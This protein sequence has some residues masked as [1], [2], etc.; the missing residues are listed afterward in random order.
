MVKESDG[1]VE[2]AL[3]VVREVKERLAEKVVVELDGWDFSPKVAEASPQVEVLRGELVALLESANVSKIVLRNVQH[4]G[5]LLTNKMAKTLVG[6][7]VH[8]TIFHEHDGLVLGSLIISS[9]VIE[10]VV[11]S[12][13]DSY[14]K[15]I[16]SLCAKLG[17]SQTLRT[18]DFSH[19][20][21]MGFVGNV[22]SQV[23][24]S[25]KALAHISL[26]HNQLRSLGV[27]PIARA[28]ANSTQLISIALT[29]NHIEKAGLDDLIQAVEALP[30][31][32]PLETVVLD[33]N[34]ALSAADLARL[35]AAMG[36]DRA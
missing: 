18:L 8:E 5:R 3:V 29:D 16:I 7:E 11:F 1:G 17:K 27:R 6:I 32:L 4:T 15:G 23:V 22:I 13:N 10:S 9:P 35:A 12:G 24:E 30:A 26:A 25:A 19:N 31:G 33:E 14:S 28:L 36:S 2:A 20:N 34:P 21:F